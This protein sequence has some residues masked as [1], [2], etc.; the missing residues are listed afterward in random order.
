MEKVTAFIFDVDGVL[1]DSEYANFVSL[2]RA[3]ENHLKVTIN[4]TDDL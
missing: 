1:V 3:L 4:F 2:N